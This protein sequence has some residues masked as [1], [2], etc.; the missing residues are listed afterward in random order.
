[1]PTSR[2]GPTG[3]TNQVRITVERASDDFAIIMT[4][5]LDEQDDPK[6][7]P[8]EI[9]LERGTTLDL[10]SDLVLELKKPKKPAPR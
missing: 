7:Y 9:R 1:M 10:I 8:I 2:S 3:T 4:V 6:G 5:E